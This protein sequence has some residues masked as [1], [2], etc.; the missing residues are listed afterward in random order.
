MMPS[1]TFTY[2]SWPFHTHLN[3][4]QT[5]KK[6]KISPFITVSH[7]WPLPICQQ[8]GS[9]TNITMGARFLKEKKKEGNRITGLVWRQRLETGMELD[10]AW[11]E[12]S[13]QPLPSQLNSREAISAPRRKLISFEMKS[14]M[15]CWGIIPYKY[16]QT[17]LTIRHNI[18]FGALSTS[19]GPRW[20]SHISK[21]IFVLSFGLKCNANFEFFQFSSDALQLH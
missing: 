18:M 1:D 13:Q 5:H 11:R 21:H 6:S 4:S 9:K 3:P 16:P 10:W 17:S 2:N 8:Q 14:L 19:P 20:I 7:P 12:L 15:N